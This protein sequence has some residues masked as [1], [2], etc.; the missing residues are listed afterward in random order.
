MLRQEC[1]SLTERVDFEGD[2][3]PMARL[4]RAYFPGERF[5]LTIESSDA[6]VDDVADI[7]ID[8]DTPGGDGGGDG[9]ADGVA[10]GADLA[11]VSDLRDG[12]YRCEYRLHRA[13]RYRLGVFCHRARRE[14]AESPFDLF[15]APAAPDPAT[16][17]ASGDGLSDA[18]A[19]IEAAF[20]LSPT[21][22]HGNRAP[23][24]RAAAGWDAVVELQPAGTPR[25]SPRLS[26]RCVGMPP[27]HACM[28]E[29][30][31]RDANGA[32][33]QARRRR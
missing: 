32:T 27:R 16:T 24:S 12:T 7:D 9:Y 31:R 25:L 1:G 6:H 22:A 33:C 28:A 11:H 30:C 10:S 29:T 5:T 13:G 23:I 8:D 18:C 3:R 20:E 4:T 19:G 26:P 14:I 21:D 2:Y 15:I 17:T